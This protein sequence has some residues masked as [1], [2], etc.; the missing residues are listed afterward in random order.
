MLCCERPKDIDKVDLSP[1][2][3]S[4]KGQWVALDSYSHGFNVVA[5][6]NSMRAVYDIAVSNGIQTPVMI[7]VSEKLQQAI[8]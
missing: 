6:G 2:F 5:C 4:H 7:F 8:M 3:K 1:L